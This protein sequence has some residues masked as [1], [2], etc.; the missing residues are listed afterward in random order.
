MPLLGVN[1][2]PVVSLKRFG[3]LRIEFHDCLRFIAPKVGHPVRYFVDPVVAVINYASAQGN[4]QVAMIGFSGGGWTT[5]LSAAVDVR[6]ARS[7]PVAG[8]LPLYLRSGSGYPWGD[9]EQTVR[10]LYEIA[11]YLELYVLGAVGD[12]SR[13]QMQILNKHAPCI[14]A[15][16][17]YLTYERIVGEIVEELGSGRFGVVLDDTHRQHMIS[18]WAVRRILEDLEDDWRLDGD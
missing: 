14:Y 5:T 15:G 6:I 7:Y 11:N 1:N 10:G 18:K 17:G 4:R 16:T 3:R 9:Y 12:A 2:R 13:A 8:T